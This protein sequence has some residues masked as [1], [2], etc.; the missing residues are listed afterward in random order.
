MAH[1]RSTKKKANTSA[2]ATGQ[3]NNIN[4]HSASNASKSKCTIINE[5]ADGILAKRQTMGVNGCRPHEPH[6]LSTANND[7][8]SGVAEAILDGNEIL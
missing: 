3:G 4:G 5:N 2:R 8:A 1:P 6:V 7:S